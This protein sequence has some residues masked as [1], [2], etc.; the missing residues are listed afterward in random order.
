MATNLFLWRIKMGYH[1]D[2]KGELKFGSELTGSHLAKLNAILGQ[3]ARVHPEWNGHEDLDYI[4]LELLDDFSGIKWDGAE[5][6]YGMV[7]AVNM[8]TSIL[9]KDIPDFSFK[10]ELIAQGEE[11][12]DRW[13][14]IIDENGIAH[15]K[16]I[17][18]DGKRV[19]CPY[20]EKEFILE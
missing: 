9:R 12:D 7:E 1:T 20:C 8:I 14:L 10:G 16:E 5:K 15:K 2:F 13:K 18:M 17:I 19:T 3:D 4:D 6:T 11:F